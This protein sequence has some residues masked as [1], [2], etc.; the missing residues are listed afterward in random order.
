[1]QRKNLLRTAL[2]ITAFLVLVASSVVTTSARWSRA[3]EQLAGPLKDLLVG[4]RD[5]A[6]ANVIQELKTWKE[7]FDRG[8]AAEDL[9]KLNGLRGRAAELRKGTIRT[10]L[11]LRNA[12]A[13]DDFA[14]VSLYKRRLKALADKR[15]EL[16][17]ELK[18]IAVKYKDNLVEIG[19]TAKPFAEDW[20]E[21]AAKIVKDWY[22]K[23]K[24]E[25]SPAQKRALG[26]TVERWK[27]WMG[28]DAEKRAKIAAARFLL[29]DGSDL[30]DIASMMKLQDSNSDDVSIPQPEGYSL[31]PNYPNPFNPATTIRFALPK[32]EHV[33]LKVYDAL[34][35]E[36]AT[37]INADLNAGEHSVVFDA[38]NL[39][40]GVYIY[41]I[42]AGEFVQQNQM[43]LI[44]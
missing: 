43:Q 22:E 9:E 42:Q 14:K 27:Q 2:L 40:S 5:W 8:V 13:K 32:S 1:M 37:L 23:H 11:A 18:P 44:K 4:L 30:P 10:A 3:D 25:L 16:L 41:R 35:R 36:V 31:S 6:Q 7:Q 21:S 15:A 38:K 24:Q 19:K 26:K 17:K 20:R 39:S 34:G 29:W 33:T 12:W 28:L